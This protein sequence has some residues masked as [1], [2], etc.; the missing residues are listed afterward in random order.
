[1]PRF[2]FFF[3]IFAD[4]NALTLAFFGFWVGVGDI[5]AR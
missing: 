4:C 1:M 2:T 3:F 5:T